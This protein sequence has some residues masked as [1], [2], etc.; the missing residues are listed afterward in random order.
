MA[1]FTLYSM[2][3]HIIIDQAS[4]IEMILG[5]PEM[6]R[7]LDKLILHELLEAA[8]VDDKQYRISSKLDHILY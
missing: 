2:L 6:Q 7:M 1:H 5:G 3:G 4:F 8:K